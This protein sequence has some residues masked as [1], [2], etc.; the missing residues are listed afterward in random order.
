MM[1]Q[2]EICHV[3]QHGH[4]V[5]IPTEKYAPD[6]YF[7]EQ[8]R[9]DLH[10]YNPHLLANPQESPSIQPLSDGK[11]KR[12]RQTMNSLDSVSIEDVLQMSLDDQ[13]SKRKRRADK[14]SPPEVSDSDESVKGS[15]TKRARTNKR[16]VRDG[17]SA[18]EKNIPTIEYDNASTHGTDPDASAVEG[19]EEMSDVP[20]PPPKL[21]DN[22][23]FAPTPKTKKPR[24]KRAGSPGSVRGPGRGLDDSV[25]LKPRNVNQRASLMEMCRR[26][27]NV[28]EWAHRMHG[29]RSDE[30]TAADEETYVMLDR[31]IFQ[32]ETFQSKYR[33]IAYAQRRANVVQPTP[34]QPAAPPPAKVEEMV[35]ETQTE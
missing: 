18:S 33:S 30:V 15:Q 16:S 9:P 12:G 25:P 21:K 32:L 22:L 6:H 23:L 4:C 13:S 31:L 35:L 3:W 11:V 26:V 20:P 17:S 5:N 7:C 28:L 34:S 29:N 14:N 8:C 1:V 2:C 24:N 19:T 27:R 10:P